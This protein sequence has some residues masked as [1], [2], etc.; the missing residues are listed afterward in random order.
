MLTRSMAEHSAFEV[1]NVVL[2]LFM[3]TDMEAIMTNP[4]GQPMATVRAHIVICVPGISSE[5][6]SL[7]MLHCRSSSIAWEEMVL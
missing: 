6:L 1:I 2:S 4:I 3:G 5:L 7:N